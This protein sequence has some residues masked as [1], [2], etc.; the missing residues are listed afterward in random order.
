MIDFLAQACLWFTHKSF[1]IPFIIIGYFTFSK[2]IFCKALFILL[3]SIMLNAYLK[4]LWQIPLSPALGKEGWSF[5]SGH[6]QTAFA[7]WG[8]IAWEFKQIWFMVLI[9]FLLVVIG[10]SLVHFG[11][12]HCYD[13]FGAVGF[14]ILSLIAYD[15]LLRHFLVF[16]I[17]LPGLGLLFFI[18][19]LPMIYLIPLSLPHLWIADGALLGFSLGCILSPNEQRHNTVLKIIIAILGAYLIY[20]FFSFLRPFNSLKLIN[21]VQFFLSSLWVSFVPQKIISILQK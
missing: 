11:Y 13:I 1:L 3:F 4:S 20:K 2:E 17:N 12:H 18:L 14:G 8:W 19:A 16:K 7:F 6:M 5:P 21:F 15:A 10:F 9:I